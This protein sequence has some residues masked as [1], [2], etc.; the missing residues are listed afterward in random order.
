[1]K[2]RREVGK[3]GGREGG[4]KKEGGNLPIIYSREKRGL[5]LVVEYLL[6]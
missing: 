5:G 2:E 6:S 4:E 3:N 1:M